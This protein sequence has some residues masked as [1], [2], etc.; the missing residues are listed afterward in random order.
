MLARFL[1]VHPHPT[2]LSGGNA[3]T[4]TF[5]ACSP[6]PNETFRWKCQH[7]F[8]LLSPPPSP[9][10]FGSPLTTNQPR[11]W[12]TF[13][14]TIWWLFTWSCISLT[15]HHFHKFCNTTQ[16]STLTLEWHWAPHKTLNYLGWKN[17]C[18]VA[19]LETSMVLMALLCEIGA[20]LWSGEFA[21]Y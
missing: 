20:L 15:R 11:Y 17:V 5:S 8:Q 21:T 9:L 3:G 18:F 2:K 7:I 13:A 4:S 12:L 16:R 6:T 1:P 10:G 14:V 19:C